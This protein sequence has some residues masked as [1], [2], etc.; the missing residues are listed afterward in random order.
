MATSQPFSI[1]CFSWNASGLRLCE[2]MSQ[3]KAEGARRGFRAAVAMKKDCVPPD[4]FE[5]IRSIIR[6]RQP[7]LV[8]MVTEDEDK[9]RTFFH[10]NLLPSQMPEIGYT[11][12]KRDKLDNVGE[13]KPVKREDNIPSGKPSGSALRI[14]IYARNNIA[15]G[16][17]SK[18][19]T[20]K[21]FFKNDG[22]VSA[23]CKQGNRVA[24]AI[25]AYV[26]HEIYGKFCFI[27]ANLPAGGQS[28]RLDPNL[29]YETYRAAANSAN[30][31]CL[32]SLLNKFVTQLPDESKPDHIFLLGDLNYDIVVP[33]KSS[34]EV[35]SD[36]SGNLTATK[37]KEL[38]SYDELTSSLKEVPLRGFKEGV[39][40]EGPLFMPTWNLTRNRPSSCVPLPETN[41]LNSNCFSDEFG[42][43]WHDRILYKELM[44]SNYMAHC[45]LYNRFDIGNI[46]S[47]T[48]A[49]VI[50][51]FE[52][53]VVE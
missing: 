40:G 50:G 35:I 30:K 39:A 45:T 18:E 21:R 24:G 48:H 51:M 8:V 6:E 14:S 34:S 11:F 3:Q 42:I 20:L 44:T 53:R 27:A 7:G 15:Q 12:L 2:T 16:F 29:D 1:M 17:I 23:L 46:K 28:L 10:S 33:N 41:K 49:G 38:Q 52:M 9:S 36:L 13:L 37:L 26:W 32:I 4:F 22:Q 47:S 5:D 19:K 25:A 43:G 31:L